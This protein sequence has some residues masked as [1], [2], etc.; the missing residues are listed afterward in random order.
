V[1]SKLEYSDYSESEEKVPKE[2]RRYIDPQLK[3]IIQV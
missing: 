3:E 2:K 1:K